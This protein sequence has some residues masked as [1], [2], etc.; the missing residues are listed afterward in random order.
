MTFAPGDVVHLAGLGTGSVIE[1]RGRDRYAI[2][3]KGRVVVAAAR[4]L[5]RADGARR[6]RAK[7]D[8]TAPARTGT[9]ARTQAAASIDLHGKTTVEALELVEAFINEALLAGHAEALIVHGRGGGKV[10]V[11]VHKYLRQL[12]SAASFRLDPRNPGVTIVKFA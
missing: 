6:T 1:A 9:S 5:E 3:I 11:A 10:K 12:A 4:D 8:V 7:H 2:D